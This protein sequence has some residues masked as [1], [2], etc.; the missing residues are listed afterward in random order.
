MTLRTRKPEDLV[1][2][3]STTR[4]ANLQWTALPAL[5]T[6]K[7]IQH[8]TVHA[9]TALKIR[10]RKYSL[11]HY[12]SSSNMNAHKPF[13]GR[14]YSFSNVPYKLCYGLQG[15][16]VHMQDRVGYSQLFQLRESCEQSVRHGPHP[17]FAEASGS[18][19]H[20]HK[21]STDDPTRAVRESRKK[22]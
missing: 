10:I 18:T 2:N 12:S 22:T 21:H 1:P 11:Q 17:S 8:R 5:P 15:H 13:L 9:R 14:W 20:R 19:K 4:F 3:S 7:L 6:G 16:T